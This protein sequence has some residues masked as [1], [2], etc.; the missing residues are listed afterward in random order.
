L[1]L[2][3]HDAPDEKQS[4]EHGEEDRARGQPLPGRVA[5]VFR[6]KQSK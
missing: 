6:V 2:A 5:E 1:V 3:A 4:E